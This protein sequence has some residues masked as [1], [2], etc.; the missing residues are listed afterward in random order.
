[1]TEHNATPSSVA[2]FAASIGSAATS[3]TRYGIVAS[4]RIRLV[5]TEHLASEAAGR[6]HAYDC[7]RGIL[8]PQIIDIAKVVPEHRSTGVHIGLCSAETGSR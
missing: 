3:A 4:L 6:R 7:V 1:M 5:L 8:G 2:G